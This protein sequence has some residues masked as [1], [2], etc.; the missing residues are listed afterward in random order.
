MTASSLLP[1]YSASIVRASRGNVGTA[2][3]T[4]EAGGGS[5]A[6]VEAST[7]DSAAGVE[8]SAE[9]AGTITASYGAFQ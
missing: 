9:G 1:A 2:H 5:D 4:L 6:G 8:A 3:E 7:E